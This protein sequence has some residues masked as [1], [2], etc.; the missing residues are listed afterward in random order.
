MN[1]AEIREWRKRKG[2]TQ[3]QLA[4]A[5]GVARQTVIV[6]EQSES[7]LLRMLPLALAALE[8]LPEKCEAVAGQRYSPSEYRL[9]R[10]RSYVVGS[11]ALRNK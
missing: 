9:M 3:E 6:W 5:L 8:N 10:N 2:W 4:M 11:R 7:S 1:G